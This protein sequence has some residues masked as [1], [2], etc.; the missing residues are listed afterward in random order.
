[1]LKHSLIRNLSV[2]LPLL[3]SA[4][5]LFSCQASAPQTEEPTESQNAENMM[6][7]YSENLSIV[8]SENGLKSYHFE[9]PLMEGY[10]LARDPYREFRKGIKITMF[11][12]DSTSND[13]ATLTA[14][15]AIFY[16]NRKLWEAKGDVVV[17]QTNGRRLYTQQLFWNQSTH[18]IY[19]NVDSR[20][21]DGDEMT[22]CEGFESD[23]EMTQWKYRKLKGVTY[24]T[25]SEDGGVKSDSTK[26]DK[27][28][29][30]KEPAK[31]TAKPAAKPKTAN[32][33]KAGQRPKTPVITPA[34]PRFDAPR[35]GAQRKVEPIQS[36]RLEGQNIEDVSTK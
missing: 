33:P 36:S 23:E 25:M 1:M 10:T 20:I 26:V 19:S 12:E 9:T 14:N 11:E 4:I 29:P 32:K 3:G 24:F 27:T 5:L 21:V 16:E 8:M 30:K 6:T 7:E 2:A 28:S 18:R 34:S 31:S 22:D 15:Y 17:I 35:S 13:A